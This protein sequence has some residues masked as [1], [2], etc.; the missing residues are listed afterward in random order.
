MGFQFIIFETMQS[1][2]L[3][4]SRRPVIPL[5]GTERKEGNQK[6][7]CTER[8]GLRERQS[9]RRHKE[10]YKSNKR[11]KNRKLVARQQTLHDLDVVREIT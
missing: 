11:I 7:K 6:W 2:S 9:E 3:S 4:S 1:N 10:L 5:L 8:K